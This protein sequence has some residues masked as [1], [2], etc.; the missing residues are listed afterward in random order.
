MRRIICINKE[1]LF[2]KEDSLPDK[3]TV[4]LPHCYNRLD[5]IDGDN[6]YYRGKADYIKEFK[7]PLKEGE[8]LWV[9][10]GAASM[11]CDVYLNDVHL[12]SHKG[13]YS[14][15]RVNLTEHLKEDNV[16]KA[17]V[18]NSYRD[19]YYPQKADFTFYGG[20]YRDV[21]F[22]IVDKTHFDLGYY[23]GKGIQVTPELNDALDE[24]KITVETWSNGKEVTVTIGEYSQTSV[25]KDGHSITVFK[26]KNP[27]LW[28]GLK[29]PY[30]YTAKA[31]VDGRDEVSTRFGIRKCVIDPER[32]FILNNKEYRVIGAGK[33]QDRYE[34]GYAISKADME[35]DMSLIKELGFTSIRLA[36]YQH[37]Q[38]FYDLCDENGVLVWAEIPYITAHMKEGRENTISQMKELVIQNYNHPSIYCWTLSNEITTHGG[39]NDDLVDNIVTL[40]NLVHSLDKTRVTSMSH[41]FILKPKE[42]I[43]RIA[44]VGA[45]N[46]YYGWYVGDLPQNDKFMDNY[47]KKYPKYPMGLSEFGAD[48][49]IQ[50]QTINPVKGDYSEAYQCLYHEH[51]LNMWSERKYIWCLYAWN[52]CD[53][54]ADGRNEGGKKG[55]NQKG[56]ITFDRKIKKDAFYLYKAYL[57]DEKFVH[58]C[59]KRYE[60][61]SEEETLIKVYSNLS[62]VSLYVDGNFVEEKTGYKV[63]EFNYRITGKHHVEVRAGDCTDSMDIEKVTEKPSEYESDT[64][65]IHNW[66]DVEVKKGYFSLKDSAFRIKRSPEGKKL[67]DKYFYP[68][69]YGITSKYGDVSSGVKIP[70]I[71]YKIVELVPLEK[72]F[73]MMGTMASLDA[74]EGLAQGLP[75]IKK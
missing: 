9:E 69:I 55:Q 16:L 39:V 50:Y 35:E 61:R 62:K 12:Y 7:N 52:M 15:F 56:L 33:H 11:L 51:I 14:L 27:H 13:G 21:N 38:Y 2:S 20:I 24:C 43:V 73:K 49:N 23:G 72:L 59:G 29:D 10:F 37:D 46:L 17:V 70:K 67:L 5:G 6:S 34:K 36:H 75:E 19:D 65:R 30:L 47:H 74:V 68:M 42:K 1:W 45:Y 32:G 57:S 26:M 66:F 48:A 28:N 44:D 40:N 4:D 58:L 22:I 31:I 64:M 18:D 8:E 25:V 60:K 3:E 63:F 71:A 53:F 54:G 41:V